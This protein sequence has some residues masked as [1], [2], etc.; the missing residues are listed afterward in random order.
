MCKGSKWKN[1]EYC[2][3][4]CVNRNGR[5][6]EIAGVG[7]SSQGMDVKGSTDCFGELAR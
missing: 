1:K 3:S 5:S 7:S 4:K 6:A 2:G